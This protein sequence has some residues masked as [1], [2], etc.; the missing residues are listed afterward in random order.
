MYSDDVEFEKISDARILSYG[1]KELRGTTRSLHE[2]P[3]YPEL[4]M[5]KAVNSPLVNW[6]EHLMYKWCGE[7]GNDLP[8]AKVESISKTG[9]YLV[10]ERLCTARP[11]SIPEF[12]PPWLTDRKTD[13]FRTDSTGTLKICDYGSVNL[14]SYIGTEQYLDEGANNPLYRS[15]DALDDGCYAQLRGDRIS[16]DDHRDVFKCKVDETKVVIEATGSYLENA[17]EF[18]IYTSLLRANATQLC[19]FPAFEISAS[20][21]YIVAENLTSWDAVKPTAVHGIPEWLTNSVRTLRTDGAGK[22]KIESWGS[23]DLTPVLKSVRDV[24]YHG[25]PVPLTTGPKKISLE[26]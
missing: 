3:G 19:F 2:I 22:F 8:L 18:L 11:P 6:T 17:I 20:G 16:T 12:G 21:R 7:R 4:I 5:K 9:K 23:T 10:M 24:R 1:G 13:A 14:G 25:V 26:P 15:C